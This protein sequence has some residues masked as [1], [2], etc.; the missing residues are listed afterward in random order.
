MDSF[1]ATAVANNF[2]LALRDRGPDGGATHHDA[3]VLLVHRRL[4]I[5]DLSDAAAQ[6][7]WNEDGTICVIANG[8]VYNHRSL[9]GALEE[10]GHRFRSR[11]DSEVIVHLYED[12]GIDACAE[13]LQGMFAF[14]LWDSRIRELF[15]VRD[16][17][18]I[19]PLVIAEHKDGITFA[20]TLSGLLADSAVPPETRDEALVAFLKWG[21]IPTP[22]SAVRAARRV[23]PGSCLSIRQGRIVDEHRWWRDL[24]SDHES[25]DT[26]VRRSIDDAVCSHLVADVPIGLLLSAGIDSG[27][28]TALAT[29]HVPASTLRAWTVSQQ[30]C[31]EDEYV[32]SAVIAARLAI[33]HSEAPLGGFGL[34][35]E[36]FGRAVKGMDEPL[37]TSSVVGLHV[38]FEAIG[39]ERRVVLSGDGGDELFGGYDWHNGMPAVPSWASGPLF[40]TVSRSFSRLNGRGGRVGTIGKVAAHVRRHPASI[41]LDKL[42][43]AA[44]DELRA[45]GV[46]DLVDDP[47]EE[48]AQRAWDA[49]DGHG[50]IEQMLAVDRS[51]ALVDEM[52]AKVDCA[53]MAYSVEARVPFLDD[54]VVAL[55]KGVPISRKR[56]GEVGKVFLRDWYAEL[57]TPELAWRKK[58]GFNSPVR[59][60]LQG[61]AR[62]QLLD[63]AGVALG[64]LGNPANSAP[65]AARLRFAL[66]VLGEWLTQ[67]R[68]ASAY[69]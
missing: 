52:L 7:L 10:V 24:P 42:R 66:G 35:D 9:R 18:G 8:E 63:R 20:S 57:A 67:C 64:R 29:G 51:T 61:R 6:P 27:I 15:L 44:D 46:G 48:T 41:Y 50:V 69:S 31:A 3:D 40:R 25:T 12:R 2:Q 60:W 56:N 5:I 54:G 21:F 38:L 30:G 45:L 68:S 11:S 55:A 4:A 53:S 28:I 19:K 17:L 62:A 39:K 36:L 16:R 26:E 65:P 33:P 49:F 13:S 14:A 22:W 34:T 37:A 23:L 1:T 58:S 59:E 43:L 47:I 32:E